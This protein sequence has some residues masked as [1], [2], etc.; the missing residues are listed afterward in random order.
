[1]SSFRKREHI[2]FVELSPIF[3]R[4]LQEM[5]LFLIQAKERIIEWAFANHTFALKLFQYLA[6]TPLSYEFRFHEYTE[7]GQSNVEK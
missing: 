7:Y 6:K 5:L 1:M 3:Y 2:L 4:V